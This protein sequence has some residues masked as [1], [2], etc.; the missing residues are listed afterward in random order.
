MLYHRPQ[1]GIGFTT[2]LLPTLTRMIEASLPQVAHSS[3][4]L[5]GHE[6]NFSLY[7]YD[8]AGL[9]ASP[10][11]TGFLDLAVGDIVVQKTRED[12]SSVRVWVWMPE[13]E[14]ANHGHRHPSLEDYRLSFHKNGRVGWVTKSALKTYEYRG[15]S[16]FGNDGEPAT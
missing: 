5:R 2:L 16:P 12:H 11:A 10:A 1:V 8:G 14:I 6:T 15:R 4:K 9:P 3:R 13:W 7:T